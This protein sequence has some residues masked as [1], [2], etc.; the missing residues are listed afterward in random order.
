MVVS[1]LQLFLVVSYNW[2]LGVGNVVCGPF[3]RCRGAVGKLC[4]A[5]ELRGGVRLLYFSYLVSRGR[6]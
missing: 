6:G 1:S 4:R 3:Q 5:A 2:C